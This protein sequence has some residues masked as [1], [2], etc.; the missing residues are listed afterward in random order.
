MARKQPMY[1]SEASI[2]D[3]IA[4]AKVDYAEGDVDDGGTITGAEVAA[5]FNVTNGKINA[6]IAA[7]ENHGLL[8]S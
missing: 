6:I 5:V 4:D 2:Q 3:A 1:G 8:E 7:L